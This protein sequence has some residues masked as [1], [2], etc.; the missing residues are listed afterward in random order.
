VEAHARLLL[1]Y[2]DP[3][4]DDAA[5][6]AVPPAASPAQP[7]ASDAGGGGVPLQPARGAMVDVSV[8]HLE[9]VSRELFLALPCVVAHRIDDASPLRGVRCA[10]DLERIRAEL[11]LLLEGATASTSQ[12]VQV[13]HGAADGPNDGEGAIYIHTYIHTYKYTYT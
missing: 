12:T 4:S 5:A 8:A 1:Y 2:V 9:L 11:V 13:R 3:A 6:S 10:E 7:P